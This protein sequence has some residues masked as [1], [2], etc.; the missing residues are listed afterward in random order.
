MVICPAIPDEWEP[1]P[2][3]T[4]DF[5]KILAASKIPVEILK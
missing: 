1:R 5:E 2:K 3:C 4:D